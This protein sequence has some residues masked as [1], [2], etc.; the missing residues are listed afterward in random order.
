MNEAE[1]R[2]AFVKWY[3]AKG[4][5]SLSC[6]EAWIARAALAE[7]AAEPVVYRQWSSKWHDWIYQTE[8]GDLR[9]DTPVEPLYAAHPPR[10]PLTE[11]PKFPTM[12]R[13]MWTGREV[14][15]WI[16]ANWADA[17]RSQSGSEPADVRG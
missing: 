6:W 4:Q 9:L 7:P 8:R 13:K 3:Y 17:I 12:L 14:Q 11:T 1:E 2:K 5:E 10:A 15:A 16:D